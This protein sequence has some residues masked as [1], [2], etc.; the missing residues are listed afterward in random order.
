MIEQINFKDILNVFIIIFAMINIIGSIPIILNLK[1]KGK[2]VKPLKACFLSFILL[3]CFLFVGEAFLKLFGLDVS[4][5]AIAGSFVIFI[6][7]LEMILEREIVKSNTDISNDATFFPIV[8]PLIAGAGV[9]TTLLTI[10]SQYNA[11]NIMFGIF[12]N[13]IIIYIVIKYAKKI[14]KLLGKN[15]IHMLTKFFGIILLAISVKIF[16]TNV[17]LLIANIT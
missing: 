14:E 16:I 3:T 15:A 4:S 5:F 1:G 10:K 7:A 2:S 11:V 6:F 17:S 12:F 8:F 9:L 13:L